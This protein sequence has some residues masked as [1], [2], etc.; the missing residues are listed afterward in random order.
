M[1]TYLF[2]IAAFCWGS[3]SLDLF[4]SSSSARLT[5]HQLICKWLAAY[6]HL[7]QSESG[8]DWSLWYNYAIDGLSIMYQGDY[9]AVFKALGIILPQVCHLSIT[10]L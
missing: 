1:F 5:S 3:V 4:S 10:G 6:Y 9:I 2:T 8:E 7:S